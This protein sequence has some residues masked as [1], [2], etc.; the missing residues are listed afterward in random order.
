MESEKEQKEQTPEQRLSDK[1]SATDVA[2]N[3]AKEENSTSARED[4]RN[5]SRRD[6]SEKR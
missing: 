3:K 6:G 5:R 1:K 2:A 4:E